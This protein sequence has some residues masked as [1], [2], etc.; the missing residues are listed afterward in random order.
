MTL[1]TN[2]KHKKEMLFGLASAIAAL[3]LALGI[4]GNARWM[5][6]LI[7]GSVSLACLFLI[8]RLR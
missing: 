8:G 3:T 1:R 5:D 4:E 2:K 6:A 7:F